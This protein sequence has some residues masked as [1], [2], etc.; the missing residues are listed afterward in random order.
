MPEGLRATPPARK[1]QASQIAVLTE[2]S[3]RGS[4][5]NRT[6]REE[7]LDVQQLKVLVHSPSKK[8]GPNLFPFFIYQ[9][10]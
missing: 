9:L 1:L 3:G 8:C 5:A 6:K 7:P 10:H 4:C 2:V